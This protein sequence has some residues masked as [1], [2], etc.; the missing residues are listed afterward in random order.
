MKTSWFIGIL[1]MFGVFTIISGV[2]EATT[3]GEDEVGL[4][5]TLMTPPVIDSTHPLGVVFSVMSVAWDYLKNLFDILW[6]NYAFFQ[7]QWLIIKYIFFLPISVAIIISLI[8][9]LRGVGSN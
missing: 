7:G 4:F 2:I 1:V 6:F 9:V 5:K 8:F 3:L